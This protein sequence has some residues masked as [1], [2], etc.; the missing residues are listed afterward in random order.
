VLFYET[1]F[2]YDK[3]DYNFPHTD[4]VKDIIDLPHFPNFI[5]FETNLVTTTLIH[6]EVSVSKYDAP[7]SSVHF[8]TTEFVAQ[9][10][11]RVRKPPSYLANYHCNNASSPIYAST[12]L[13]PMDSYL[14]YSKCFSNHTAFCLSISSTI[15][16]SSYKEAS[17]HECWRK[18]MM[19]ELQT[20]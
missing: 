3:A 1:H 6:D 12:I 4:N 19:A 18:A 16:A 13:Y 9:V 7:L 11:T 14:S 17:Q 2:P 10:P 8:P 5:Q 20:L 15:D